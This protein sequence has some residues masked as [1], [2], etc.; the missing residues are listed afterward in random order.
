MATSSL[1]AAQLQN[2]FEIFN[3]Q[4]GLLEESYRDL[5]DTV[6]SLTRQLRTEQSARLTELVK[7]E[8]LSRRLSELLE[9]LPGGILVIDG[10]GIILQQNSQASALLNQPLIGCSWAD[11]VRREVREGGSEDGNIQL[12]DGRWLSLSRR[13]LKTEPGEVL[14]LADVTES[15]RMA[16]L[17]ERNERLTAIGEMTAEFAHQ[18]RTPLAS[19]MLYADKLDRSSAANAR[20]ADK[21]SAGLHEL[22][23]MVNDM[24]GFAAGA[25]RSQQQIS[26]RDLLN[27]VAQ[28]LQ[29][30][31]GGQTELRVSVTDE[32]LTVAANPDALKGALLNLITNAD[33]AGNGR[34]SI[35][36]HGH[37]FGDALH[38]CVTDDG[39]GI[40][41]E[42]RER[43]FEPF[44]TT[45]PQGTG[46]GLSVV[47]AVAASHG[48][49]VSVATSNLG[50][51][52][53]I[54]LPTHGNDSNESCGS[55]VS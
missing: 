2:A 27:N 1:D 50:T 25:R 48:G 42:L 34:A 20:V 6:E 38:L 55:D 30:Q 54:Q 47:K 37:R 40:P 21:I 4:S 17:R 22:K 13:P 28:T 11:I 12:C 46:L 44:F 33:Q 19:A 23:R 5:Q 51:C 14:L 26:V 49:E 36:L 41:E 3:Q 18:V 9:T 52:F 43:V 15:R 29:G 53:T 10:C 7:K 35:L 16:E 24:L 45:R 32:S 31:L 39:P 8:R